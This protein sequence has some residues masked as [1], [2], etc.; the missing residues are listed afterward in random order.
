MKRKICDPC[1]EKKKWKMYGIIYS[2]ERR[3]RRCCSTD[4]RRFK[5]WF[6]DKW[7]SNRP[8]NSL[9]LRT[10][11]FKRL[12]NAIVGAMKINSQEITRSSVVPRCIY[13]NQRQQVWWIH[14]TRQNIKNKHDAC[15]STLFDQ[16]LE[17]NQ[18]ASV[19]VWRKIAHVR[20]PQTTQYIY[21]LYRYIYLF[22]TFSAHAQF[23]RCVRHKKAATHNW[24]I[25]VSSVQGNYKGS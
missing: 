10:T 11:P 14:S 2:N 15:I 7:R 21:V 25:Q 3:V 18:R 23:Y 20:L 5:N 16:C 4:L 1:H 8:A 22:R 17:T 6:I 13:A 19:H 12:V 9:K 24:R